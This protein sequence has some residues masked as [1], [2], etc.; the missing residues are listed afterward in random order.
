MTCYKCFGGDH[1]TMAVSV[2]WKDDH[3]LKALDFLLE[4]LLQG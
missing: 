1:L 3:V 4:Q 2:L